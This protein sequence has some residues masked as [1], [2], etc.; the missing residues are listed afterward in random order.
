MLRLITFDIC[1]QQVERLPLHMAI[2]FTYEVANIDAAFAR[3]RQRTTLLM[4][5]RFAAA[6]A[7]R[8]RGLYAAF[9]LFYA[10]LLSRFEM[11][12]VLPLIFIRASPPAARHASARHDRRRLRS[13]VPRRFFFYY[14]LC[15]HAP[16][17]RLHYDIDSAHGADELRR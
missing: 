3:L 7:A 9:R 11:L 1:R 5:L 16:L 14:S 8:G 10:T 6:V 15:V 4:P 17:I 2:F 12:Y 13:Y